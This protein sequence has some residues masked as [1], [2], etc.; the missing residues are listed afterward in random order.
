MS[1]P[2]IAKQ[3]SE[4]EKKSSRFDANGWIY[5]HVEGSPFERGFQHGYLLANEI[6]DAL[7][8]SKY[9]AKWDTG[10]EFEV[11]VKAATEIFPRRM[12]DEFLE[13]IKGITEG[14]NRASRT[15]KVTFDEILAWNGYQ[16]LLGNWWPQQMNNSTLGKK[17]WKG[18]K[19]H[20]CSA[21]VATGSHTHDGKIVMAHNTWDRYASGDHYNVL[22]DIVPEKGNRILMQG[23]PG[24]IS[25]TTDFWLTSAGLMVT[26]TTIA[27]FSSFDETKAPEFYR[28]RK[29][30]QYAKNIQEWVDIFS[31]ENNGGYANN[32]LL[33]DINTG[34]IAKYELGLKFRHLDKTTN[35]YYSGYNTPTD[36]KI[37]NQE[38]QEQGE[39]YSD[40][41]KNASRR[42]RWMQLMKDNCGKIDVEMAK[43]MIADHYDVYLKQDNNPCSRT[44]CGHLELDDAKY[45]SHDNQGPY[46]PWGSNDAKVADSNM[47]TP[48]ELSLW[49][50]WGHSCGMPFDANKFIEEHPQ[51]DWLKGYMKQRPSYEWRKFTT[52]E[53]GV[54]K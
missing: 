25:S 33:G 45:G 23:V 38:C 10:E 5:L 40:I 54:A 30:C 32:W 11:F 9:L 7:R 46:Y 29:A 26:E 44:I 39:E 3:Q 14:V 37:R 4:W 15:Q 12:D 17:L 31:L 36:L 13:E 1:D 47:I 28:S 51:Y 20:H 53:N 16:E 41:R 8:T 49:A 19:G 22:I 50:R 48:T 2:E 43:C 18:K 24:Y 35:G 52:G 6:L 34:E 27:G 21:F 42:L